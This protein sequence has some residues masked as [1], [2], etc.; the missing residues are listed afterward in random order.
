MN[1]ESAFKS[2][3]SSVAPTILM[4]EETAAS[5]DEHPTFSPRKKSFLCRS[6]LRGGQTLASVDLLATHYRY[7]DMWVLCRI[8]CELMINSSYL[9]VAPESEFQ[10]WSNYDIWTDERL[11]SNLASSVPEFEAEL[12]QR[13]LEWQREQRCTLEKSQLY[14]GC[15]NSWSKK[16][17]EQR[18]KVVDDVLKLERDTFQLL[19]RLTVKI[20]NGFVHVSPKGIGPQR[21]PIVSPREP[22]P[23][24]IQAAT[25]A[26]SMSATAVYA[27]LS[28]TRAHA[29]LSEHLLANRFGDALRV[30]FGDSI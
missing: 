3:K 30:A 14:K 23:A 25:Q 21:T 5:I 18:A 27:G 17:L 28:F 15:G 7:Q 6:L 12:N 16:T 11:V 29:G 8:I 22:S 10:R 1:L 24:D 20:G 4:V 19:C 2:A 13:E 9:Q 26:L